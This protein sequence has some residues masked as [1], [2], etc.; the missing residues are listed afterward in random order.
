MQLGWFP[1]SGWTPPDED[2]GEFLRQ[3]VLPAISL[4]IV[5]GAVLTRYVRSAVLEVLREDFL[6]TARAKGSRPPAR[7]SATACATPRSR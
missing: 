5:E 3:L 6:R 7:S 4:G 2:F 1:S